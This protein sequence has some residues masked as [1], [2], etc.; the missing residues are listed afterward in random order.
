M[1]FF[2]LNMNQAKGIE[3]L[4]ILKKDGYFVSLERDTKK[5]V[6]KQFED[7]AQYDAKWDT[8]RVI[9]VLSSQL[10]ESKRVAIK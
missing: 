5:K 6:S 2:I 7:I 10:D 3:H 1:K 4:L 8:V 9:T